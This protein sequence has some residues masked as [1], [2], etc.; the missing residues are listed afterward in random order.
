MS[1][2]QIQTLT[3]NR[4]TAATSKTSVSTDWSSNLGAGRDIIVVGWT[5]RGNTLTWGTVDDSDGVTYSLVVQ[6]IFNVSGVDR[7]GV[8]IWIRHNITGGNKP[9]ITVRTSAAAT[10]EFG[11]A[12]VAGIASGTAHATNTN[13][14]ASAT[15]TPSTGSVNI[16]VSDSYGVVAYVG[17]NPSTFTFTEPSGYSSLAQETNNTTWQGGDSAAKVITGSV[18]GHNPTWT[19]SS[20]SYAACQAVF[21]A[22]GGGG[23]PST[24]TNN[25]H[26]GAIMRADLD[27]MRRM[28][29]DWNL[30]TQAIRRKRAA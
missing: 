20:S 4:A 3:K 29:R 5:Y 26:Q 24:T 6:N 18:S 17:Y 14:S 9:T 2:T 13:S 7:I 12:E 16:T 30:L 10:I 11:A 28:S 25:D 23:G 19:T 21:D 8:G 1:A 22:T 27:Q 15:T